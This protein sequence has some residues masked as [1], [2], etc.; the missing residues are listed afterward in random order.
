MTVLVGEAEGSLVGFI[1][2]EEAAVPVLH[3]VYV[4]PV[5]RGLGFFP[6]LMEA[7]GIPEGTSFL[8][9]FR[10][11]DCRQFRNGSHCPA[12]ARRRN[13]EPIYAESP[14]KRSKV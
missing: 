3:Y 1:A 13:L 2:F 11:P 4:K 7:A 9:T 8:Y 5:L 10:T 6:S 12:I 14:G